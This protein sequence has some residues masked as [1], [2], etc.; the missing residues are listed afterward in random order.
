[1]LESSGVAITPR[2]MD[3][4]QIS[5]AYLAKVLCEAG[6]LEVKILTSP[7]PH[8]CKQKRSEHANSGH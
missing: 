4:V 3:N 1:M 7:Q 2:M 6:P 8:S 5:T